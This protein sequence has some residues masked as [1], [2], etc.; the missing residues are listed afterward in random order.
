MS[1]GLPVVMSRVGALPELLG[2]SETTGVLVEAADV[3]GLASAMQRLAEDLGL[4]ERLG[5][6]ARARVLAEYTLDRMMERTLGVYERAR[7][8]REH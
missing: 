3:D 2:D 8:R 7:L 1:C 6:G 4:R 5:A